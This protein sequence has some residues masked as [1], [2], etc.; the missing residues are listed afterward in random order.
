[1]RSIMLVAASA[2]TIVCEAAL[3]ADQASRSRW[4]EYGSLQP[5]E[6]SVARSAL[7]ESLGQAAANAF[8]VLSEGCGFYDCTY[9][10]RRSVLFERADP[11][12]PSGVARSTH[13][14]CSANRD[15][16]WRCRSPYSAASL[17][18]AGEYFELVLSNSI[19]DARL[20][21]LVKYARSECFYEA[22]SVYPWPKGFRP[23]A[24][25]APISTIGEAEGSIALSLG[26]GE[27]GVDLKLSRSTG[28]CP[29][30]I[31][32]AGAWVS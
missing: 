32:K 30:A 1:M 29:F 26:N 10:V 31:E 4:S 17:T 25:G 20:I 11:V 22:V 28:A 3:P 2:L 6:I 13:V 16:S 19:G 9:V 27:Y 12:S 21:E 24:R 18:V 8:V 23:E 5:A 14:W 7:A 15:K